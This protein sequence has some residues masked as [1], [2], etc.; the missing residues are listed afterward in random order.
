M[1]KIKLNLVQLLLI[2]GIPSLLL[3]IISG[4]LVY[5]SLKELNSNKYIK[6][7]IKTY[8][9]LKD[10]YYED[11][12]DNKLIDAAING[13]F[14]YTGDDYTIYMDEDKTDALN[15]KLDGTYEGIGITITLVNDNIIIY[16]V[17]DDS[18]S[19]KAGLKK[20]DIIISI[21]GELVNGKTTEEVSKMIRENK[22]SKFEVKVL[23][24]KEEL[25]FE[26]ERKTL[27]IPAIVSSIKEV[28]DKKIGYIFIET[29]SN[30]IDTQFE[31][32][33]LTMEKDG[34]DSLIIDVRGNTG[35]YLKACTNIIEL[36]LKKG[37]LMY[38]I[39]S[40][41]DSNDYR[42]ETETSRN[43]SVVVLVN[44]NSASASEI[45]ASSL[46]YSYGATIVGT[47]TYGK[48]KVQSTD[49]LNDG[50]MVKY[51]TARWYMPNGKCLDEI[52]LQPDVEVK[53]DESYFE[54]SNEENDNQLN[55]AIEILSE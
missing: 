24:D 43:Y 23:R 45:L 1:K 36:F 28:N 13:M 10:E 49:T 52:G 46:K 44:G 3:S 39:K 53:L 8:N 12:D 17:L 25:S 32:T 4:S 19:D 2:V 18:P 47:K 29:F 50:T 15:E 35:G 37:D 48:G 22:E 5:N 9:K 42:D 7:F 34:I 38:S 6:E 55:K 26:V 30:T 51:T 40:K 20:D 21:N 27:I 11:L 14:E 33:L 41:K 54:N 31:S 16:K